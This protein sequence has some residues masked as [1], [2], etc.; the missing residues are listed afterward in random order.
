MARICRQI[1]ERIEETRTSIEEFWEK[2]TRTFEEEVCEWLPWPLDDICGFVTR[3]VSWFVKTVITVVMTIVRIIVRIVCEIVYNFLN[4]AATVLK[5]LTNVPFIGPIIRNF[6]RFWGEVWSQVIGLFDAAARL[7]GIR[8]TKYLRVCVVILAE[9]EDTPV[10]TTAE[11]DTAITFAQ[12]AFYRGAKVRL[13]VVG[14]HEL[15]RAAPRDNLDV[16]TGAGAV[17]DELWLPGGY[18]EAAANIHCYDETFFRLVGV[19]A[20]ITVFIVRSVRGQAT[21]CSLATFADYVTVERGTVRGASADPTVFAHEI[22]H[23]CNLFHV[24]ESAN[25]LAGTSG[26]GALRG[27]RLSPI[28]TTILRSSRHVTFF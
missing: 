12:N 3:V 26:P 4:F 14:I 17:W 23:A 1:E 24:G 11:L 21:G 5:S 8:I 15:S 18:F 13:Q 27:S 2:V 16:N 7:F 9:D 25:L 6:I 28:Q 10:A 22:A 19:G 20:P